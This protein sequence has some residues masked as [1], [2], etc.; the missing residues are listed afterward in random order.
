MKRTR[1]FGAALL[2]STM[3]AMGGAQAK[4]LV[5]C[6]EGSPE[7]FTPALNTTGTSFDA[8]RPVYDKL[9]EF[10]RGS[11]EVEPGL[12]EYV[13]VLDFVALVAL[14]LGLHAGIVD[15][16]APGLAH[17]VDLDAADQ[18]QCTALAELHGMVELRA[19]AAVAAVEVDDAT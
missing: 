5:Y 11:T 1:S 13:G 10:K 12:A 6:S 18:A 2:L 8:A 3:L 15:I 16:A 4:S 7:N 19:D 9:T 14:Q 17:A